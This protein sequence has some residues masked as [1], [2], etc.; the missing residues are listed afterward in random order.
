MR[1]RGERGVPMQLPESSSLRQLFPSYEDSMQ[2]KKEIARTELGTMQCLFLLLWQNPCWETEK[3]WLWRFFLEILAKATWFNN[4]L[5]KSLL[6]DIP[7]SDILENTTQTHTHTRMHVCTH[8]FFSLFFPSSARHAQ[9]IAKQRLQ[10]WKDTMSFQNMIL[11]FTLPSF[12]L[13]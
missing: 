2:G 11:N 10:L 4:T 3:Y 6:L 13:H 5:N 9:S 7:S 8:T 1:F 12:H